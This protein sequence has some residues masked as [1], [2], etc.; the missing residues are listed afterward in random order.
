MTDTSDVTILVPSSSTSTPSAHRRSFDMVRI[1]RADP[2]LVDA[3]SCAG[4][5]A[6]SPR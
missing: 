1:E 2:A 4:R 3:A 5:C 6:A